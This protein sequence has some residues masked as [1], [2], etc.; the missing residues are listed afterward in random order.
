[1]PNGKRTEYMRLYM[2][3][4]R[5][6]NPGLDAAYREKALKRKLGALMEEMSISD[7]EAFIR[8][9]QERLAAAQDG[10]REP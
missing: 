10:R 4:R 8:Q 5:A 6:A 9:K 7:L 3:K 1:M 2:Q